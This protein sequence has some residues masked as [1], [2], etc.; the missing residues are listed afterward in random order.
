VRSSD[1]DAWV[2]K[3]TLWELLSLYAALLMLLAYVLYWFAEQHPGY[4][5]WLL[6]VAVFELSPKILRDV[7]EAWKKRRR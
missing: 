3:R 4:W 7:G 6:F 2:K 1:V 5:G